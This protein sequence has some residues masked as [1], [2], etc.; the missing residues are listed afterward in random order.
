MPGQLCPHALP[1]ALEARTPATALAPAGAGR[2]AAMATTVQRQ[3]R[4]SR[5]SFAA[6]A[7]AGGSAAVFDLEG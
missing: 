3:P 5:F 4:A 2:A 1:Q 7:L 6:S